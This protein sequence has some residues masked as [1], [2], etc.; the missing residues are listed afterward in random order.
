[1]DPFNA[2]FTKGHSE[3]LAQKQMLVLTSKTMK[4]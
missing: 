1:M 2:N 4:K 3:S